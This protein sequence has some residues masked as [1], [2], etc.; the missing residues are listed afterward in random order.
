MARNSFELRNHDD[1]VMKTL[2]YVFEA[3][4]GGEAMA[5]RSPRRDEYR[6]EHEDAGQCAMIRR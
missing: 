5:M 4:D 6:S 1:E 3:D 2:A